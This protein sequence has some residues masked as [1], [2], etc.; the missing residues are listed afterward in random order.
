MILATETVDRDVVLTADVCI[1]GSGAG[2]AT[3]A[4]ELSARG[5]S[6]V[7]IEE[8]PYLDRGRFTQR[9]AATVP[10]LY[11]QLGLRAVTDATVMI[12]HGAAVGGST[13]VSDCV[14]ERLPPGLLSQWSERFGLKGLSPAKLAPFFERAEA[15]AHV[16]PLL[17]TDINANNAALKTG[18]ERLGIRHR[19]VAHNRIDCVGCGYCGLGCAYDR[20]ADART[21]DI[22]AASRAGAVIVPDCRVERVVVEQGRATGVSGHFLRSRGGGPHTLGVR[23][24]AVVLA[25]GAIGSPILWL[26][27]QLPNTHRQVGRHLHLLPQVVVAAEFADEIACWKGI[28]QAVV[29]DQFLDLD[30]RVGGGYCFAPFSAHPVAVAALLPG[31]GSAQR[32]LMQAYPRLALATVRLHDRTAGRVELD[33]GGPLTISYHLSEADRATVLDG[34]R[35]LA[36]LYLAAGAT[37]VVLPYN[38][39]VEV[40]RRGD[41]RAIDERPWHANDPLLSSYHPQGTLRM[42]TDPKRSVVNEYGRAHEVRGVFVAD[43]SVFPS[44]TAVP[45]QLAVMAL[46]QRT[47]AYMADTWKA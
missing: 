28:P 18:A 42:G 47:A 9:E 39:L 25:G 41:F 37:R 2:G 34:M 12:F 14:C 32:A 6:V 38:A 36:D 45:P 26:R 40:T 13:V 4:R 8:G 35:R 33:P 16:R 7:V 10:L 11:S 21:V 3:V 46:A 29:V 27:S 20:K 19:L 22:P 17:P 31:F 5:R 44:S 23:A 24:R 15:R 1:V 43:A 30:R